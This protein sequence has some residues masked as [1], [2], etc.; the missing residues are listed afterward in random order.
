MFYMNQFT[1]K[2]N[3]ALLWDVLLDEL[4]IK[5][6]QPSFIS[7]V[8]TVFQSNINPFIT[9]AQPNTPLI[10]LNK[11]FLG[12]VVLAV[13]KLFPQLSNDVKRITI[14]SEEIIEPY[15]IE[16]IQAE[17]LSEFDKELNM[18][19]MELENYMTLPKPK[20]VQFSDN[21]IDGKITTMDALIS[22]KLA[23]RNLELELL[24]KNNYNTINT[25]DNW[26]TSKETSVKTEKMAAKDSEHVVQQ[27]QS[28]SRLKYLNFDDQQNISL[29]ITPKK[30]SWSND[31]EEPINIFSKLKRVNNEEPSQ[32]DTSI[33]SD[34]KYV[35]QGSIPLPTYESIQPPPIQQ[36][37]QVQPSNLIINQS[38]PIIPNSEFIKQLNEINSKID[39]LYAI[40]NTLVQSINVTNKDTNKDTN[41]NKD[42]KQEQ[43]IDADM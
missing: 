43:I 1:N 5:S 35:Q 17:R 10:E 27:S 19:R 28:Q 12:Q 4:K 30:V 25:A 16:D 11:H 8:Q 21:H 22:E 6:S 14:S 26:L 37:L 2:Q 13:H 31:V 7:N 15:K 34:K 41:I 23:E 33:V 18:K 40:V 24:Q 36:P 29:N 20:G 32:N 39:N 38:T 42:I 9:R 3:L